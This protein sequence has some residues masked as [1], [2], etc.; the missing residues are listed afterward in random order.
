MHMREKFLHCL[1]VLAL[2]L[3]A[4]GGLNINRAEYFEEPG[5]NVMVFQDY[6]PEGHQSGL[7]IIQQGVR[8]AANGDM[9]LD[10]APGQ[11]SPVPAMGER[12]VDRARNEIRVSL[13]YPDP[14]RDRRGASPATYPD[15][16]FRYSVR[17]RGDGDAIRVF[18]D[19]ERPLPSAW[20]GRVGF[21]LE[22]FPG[23]LFGKSFLMDGHPGVFPRSFSGTV[24]RD[25]DGE[26]QSAPL[27]AGRMLVLAPETEE[28]RL[29]IESRGAGLSLIDGRARCE[30]GWFIVR[31]LVPSGATTNAV[32]W[33][34]TPHVVPGWLYSPVVQVSQVG[35]HPA[36]PKIAVIELDKRDPAIGEARLVRFD[37]GGSVNVALSQQPKRWGEFLRYQYLTFDFTQIR[38]PGV[39]QVQYG[40]S[41]TVPFVVST[42]VYQRG[43]WQ[44]TLDCFLPV[45]MCHMRVNDRARVWHGLCHNDDALMAPTNHIH[46]D[47][48]SQGPSTLTP[49]QPLQHVPGL[50]VGGWHDAGDYDL[51]IES[52]AETVR[53]LAL[54]FEEFNVDYDATTVDQEHKV[55][56]MHVPDGKPDVLQQ[57][58]HGALSI[59]GGYRSLGRLYRGIISPTLRQYV[60]LGDGSLMT[61]GKLYDPSLKEDEMR[62]ESSGKLDDNWV[63]TEEN[64]RRELQVASALATAVRVLKKLN[65]PLADQCLSVA[66]DLWRKDAGRPPEEQVEAAAEL[67][68]TTG[69]AEYR[70]VLLSNAPMIA[71][72]IERV[73]WLVV[74]TLPALKDPAFRERLA[75]GARDYKAKLD[76]LKRENPYG[77]PYRPNIWGAGWEIQR[78]GVRCYFLHKA[79]PEI[80]STEYMLSSLNFILGCH[81]GQ[82]TASFVSGV[83]ANSLTVAYGANRADWSYIPGG[84]ASGTALIRPDLP[85]LKTWPFLWQQTEYVMGGGATDFLFLA[86][87]ADH[88]LNQGQ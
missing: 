3:V 70:N 2:P 25:S 84:V 53:M 36:Q 76:D 29:T 43:V 48:Y 37:N 11:W 27:A 13:G 4:Q 82:N 23:L 30:N 47:S 31:S 58:E 44:P 10:P 59:V 28:Q 40:N 15:L 16:R 74:R 75:E 73:G 86:L 34:I 79:F 20:I 87:A 78:F 52:Q 62:G 22:L 46:F 49:F 6:Y 68:L 19:L 1:L 71:H 12:N 63:F 18:V 61:D 64:P 85:E 8:V 50:N 66:E 21:N 38:E 65:P 7:T 17:V 88:A 72:Q 5:L 80:F 9:R 33:V 56:E 51:R 81:P 83:G 14:A 32:E 57:V 26:L 39:Y 77:I 67:F 42:D 35:Y 69:K 41:R 60:L 45:Q 55:V 54:A 24:Y